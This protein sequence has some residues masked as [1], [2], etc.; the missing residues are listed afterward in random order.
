ML[1]RA[2]PDQLDVATLYELLRLRVGVFVVE[3][4]CPYPELDGRDLEPSTVH[5]WITGEPGDAVLGYLRLLA[6]GERWRVGRVCTARPA[7]GTGLG[8]ELMRAALAE[9]GDAG[10][11]LD[12]QS[13]LAGF[14]GGFGYV[15]DGDEFLEDGIPHVPMVRPV[16]GG[17]S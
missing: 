11:V 16:G 14:Y 2:T 6:E 3:Q 5:L 13:H 8:R 9:I 1:H 12:A 7:R 17:G 15:Q 4:A 10:S